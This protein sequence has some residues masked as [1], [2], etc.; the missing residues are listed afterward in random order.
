MCVS[1]HASEIDI[2]SFKVFVQESSR[3][4]GQDAVYG[5]QMMRAANVI[6]RKRL[7]WKVKKDLREAEK[8]AVARC[9]HTEAFVCDN[10]QSCGT[11]Q[12]KFAV[13]DLALIKT[14]SVNGHVKRPQEWAS[15][16]Y[17][18][19]DVFEELLKIRS[20]NGHVV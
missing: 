4:F 11:G 20:K 9:K 3:A 14:E 7:V 13:G 5:V 18:L 6:I 1:R 2:D 17:N 15:G 19:E 8:Q 16:P 12:C 10:K